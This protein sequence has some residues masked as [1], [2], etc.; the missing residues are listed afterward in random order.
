MAKN[1]T[2]NKIHIKK[3]DKVRVIA[4]A[5][6]GTEG[7]VLE[8]IREKYRA[9]VE[10]VNMVKKHQKPTNDSPG[11]INEVEAPV[12]ISNLMLVD[13]KTGEPTRVGRKV[14][15]EKLVRYSKKSGEIIK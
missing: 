2:V 5:Y 4:G 6:K 14:V 15:D 10:G 3:G 9:V 13:P 11:G 8:V 1:S 7:S 12:H